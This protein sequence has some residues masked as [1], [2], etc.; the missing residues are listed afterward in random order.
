MPIPFSANQN[1]NQN[2][3]LNL[4]PPVTI[5]ELRSIQGFLYSES[6]ISMPNSNSTSSR[7]TVTTAD[8]QNKSCWICSEDEVENDSTTQSQSEP[9][10]GPSSKPDQSDRG[11]G[12]DEKAAG[13]SLSTAH[14]FVHPCHCT[15]VAHEK[16]S[17]KPQRNHRKGVGGG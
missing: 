13:N 9:Q 16:V 14:G 8:L 1:Q 12:G 10:A 2:Q 7:R 4:N 11:R 15:L 17:I 6:I 3:N 5:E